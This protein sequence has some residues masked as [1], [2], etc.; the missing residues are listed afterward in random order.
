M[1]TLAFLTT[2][3][4]IINFLMAVSTFPDKI[5]TI[6]GVLVKGWL[7]SLEQFQILSVD[8]DKIDET[9]WEHLI[10]NWEEYIPFKEIYPEHRIIERDI[11][12]FYIDEFYR[13]KPLLDSIIATFSTELW[14]LQVN[15][16]DIPFRKN[17]DAYVILEHLRDIKKW[18][19]VGFFIIQENNI[20]ND[21]LKE[22]K[23]I[24]NAVYY[25]NGKI[26]KETGI[27]D[28]VWK[29]DKALWSEYLGK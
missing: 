26:L 13:T 24:Y 14:V 5:W 15:G 4:A 27:M 17:S 11:T 3:S 6:W 23:S 22:T 10:D 2:E 1:D 16:K 19:R 7:E 18:N 29:D 21:R 8:Y 9:T 12:S 20:L 28:F 25:L